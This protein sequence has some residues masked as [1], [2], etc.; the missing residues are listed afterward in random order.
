MAPICYESGLAAGHSAECPAFM[1]V[2][3]ETYIKEALTNFFSRVSSN[4]PAYIKTAEYKRKV[5]HDEE[6]AARGEVQRTP[7]GLL[8]V[9]VE[10][11]RK[12]RRLGM[13]DLRLAECLGDEYLSMVPLIAGSIAN[14]RF[15]DADGVEELYADAAAPVVSAKPGAAGSAV[16]ATG[17]GEK[18][19]EG[20]P[21]PSANSLP[22]EVVPSA[23]TIDFGDPPPV[24][25]EEWTW[26]GGMA[27]DVDALDAVLDSCLAVGI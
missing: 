6:R 12:R 25:D 15:L 16:A 26:N 21:K 1:N 24:V 8:P 10:E 13:E 27:G 23:Y 5:A 9:E 3:T 14:G 2:A 18:A 7:G 19:Q 11:M 20:A 4:G 17:A 22:E